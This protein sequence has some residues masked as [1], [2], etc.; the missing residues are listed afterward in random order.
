MYNVS[1]YL[2]AL[3]YLLAGLNHFRNTRMYERIMPPAIPWHRFFVYLTGVWEMIA[4]VLLL[5]TRTRAFAA[6]SI[7]LLLVLVFPANVQMARDFKR[8]KNKYYWLAVLRL[9]LQVLLVWW[10]W[11]YT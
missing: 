3:L 10:A 6:W 4:A 5:V 2:M 1:L 9:P 7:I 8:K 11:Q